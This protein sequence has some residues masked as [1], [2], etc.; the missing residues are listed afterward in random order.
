MQV[1]AR[2][3]QDAQVSSSKLGSLIKDRGA[4]GMELLGPAPTG[5]ARLK[6]L[7]AYQLLVRAD[8]MERL[9]HLLEPAR[10]FREGGVRV[11]VEMNPRQLDD[12]LE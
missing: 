8:T 7:Y 5:I 2:R 4:D 9:T 10:S 11:R 12:L 6:G 3:Q 1:A